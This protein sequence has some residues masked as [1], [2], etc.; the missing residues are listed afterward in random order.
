MIIIIIM[1][2]ARQPTTPTTRLNMMTLDSAPRKTTPAPSPS[3]SHAQAT[4]KE[5]DSQTREKNK[6]SRACKFPLGPETEPAPDGRAD[7]QASWARSYVMLA[8][9]ARMCARLGVG[10]AEIISPP[11]AYKPICGLGSQTP[12]W[13]SP[14]CRSTPAP[15]STGSSRPATA[16]LEAN[17]SI[18]AECHLIQL[19]VSAR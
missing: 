14:L 1:R 6:I 11:S 5:D 17:W 19:Y 12:R 8:N 7:K 3:S 4:R 2:V 10:Q 18:G 9:W 15:H 13:I 16:E